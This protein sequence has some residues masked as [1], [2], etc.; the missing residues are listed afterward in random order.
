MD[1][2]Q[3][4]AGLPV[5][6]CWAEVRRR[7]ERLGCRVQGSCG[8]MGA[9]RRLLWLCGVQRRLRGLQ[10]RHSGRLRLQGPD[11]LGSGGEDQ[12]AFRRACQRPPGHDGHH[13]NVLPGGATVLPHGVVVSMLKHY[14]RWLGLTAIG[15]Y[16]ICSCTE[17][18]SAFLS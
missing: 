5:P 6:I 1:L 12:E 8:R 11:L 13:R 3:C 10:D 18:M 16:I 15:Q 9:D 7:P 14:F 17:V 2:C 4:K